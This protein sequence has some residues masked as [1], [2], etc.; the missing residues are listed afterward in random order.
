MLCGISCGTQRL[1][2]GC[3]DGLSTNRVSCQHCALPL[4]T[5]QLRCGSCLRRPPEFSSLFAP[6]VYR[7]GIQSLIVGFKY[8]RSLPSGACLAALL[9]QSSHAWPDD[10]ELLLPL[11]PDPQRF[12]QRGFDHLRELL[13]G[14]A[15]QWR[16]RLVFDGLIRT[17]Q[18]V[19]QAGQS[20]SARRA[21]VKALFAV[22]TVVQNRRILLFDDVVTTGATVEAATRSLLAAG[23]AKVEVLAL[24]RSERSD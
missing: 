16:S 20:A 12:R 5:A 9:A 18:V 6:Y 23:C 11:P 3:Q 13:R 8:A 2:S 22:K 7:D 1:C 21:N 4:A 15:P 14:L 24:A 19:P 10:A 17:R